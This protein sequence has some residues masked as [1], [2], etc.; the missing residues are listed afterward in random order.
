MNIR[1]TM[2]NAV[3]AGLTTVLAWNTAE[4]VT[5]TVT[6]PAQL[7]AAIREMG[8]RGGTIELAGEDWR[9]GA[10]DRDVRAFYISNH[11]Q[12]PDHPVNL[13]FVGC[14]NLVVRGRGQTLRFA[15]ATIGVLIQDSVGVRLENVKLDWTRPFLS[16]MT[17]LGYRDGKTLARIDA[18]RFPYRLEDGK[19]VH[20]GDGWTSPV[21]AAFAFRGDTHEVVERSCD[22]AYRGAMT[23][24]ADG[25]VT[26]AFDFSKVGM[27]LK[28]GDVV[29]LRPA[30]RP[31]PACVV[32]RAV[33]TALE[34]V[35]IH[36]AWGMG[37]ICQMSDGF[38]WRGTR[39]AEARTSGVFPPPDSGR[40]ATLHA[41]ASHFS[42]VKGLV[43]VEN[44]LFETMMD[45]AINVHSTCLA[46]IG[47]PA[48]NRIRCRYMHPQA[49]GFGVFNPGDTLRFIRGKTLENGSETRVTAVETH[50][51]REV[52]LT[53]AAPVPAGY[54]T[55]DAVENAT[56][57]CAV[58]FRG[59]VVRNNRARGALFTTPHPV[60]V[61]NN[62]F[63][64]VSG[65][66]ILFA[67]DAQGWYE[68]G[69]C[70]D[71]LVRGNVFRDCLTSVFQFCN[72]VIS[73]YPMIRE[74][75]NQKRH[76]HRNFRIEGNLFETFD[77][78]LLYALSTD[79]ITW[80]NNTVNRH[81][82]YR[83]WDKPAFIRE[84]CTGWHTGIRYDRWWNTY[85]DAYVTK[86]FMKAQRKA[87]VTNLDQVLDI[88]RRTHELTGG[89]RQIIY[90][91]GWQYDGHDSKW[92]CW[93]KVGDQCKSRLSEDPLQSLRAAMCLCR[94]KYNCDL[95]LHLNMNDAWPDSPAWKLYNDEKLLCLDKNGKPR[96][97]GQWFRIS[98]VKEWRSGYAKK[99]ID[100]LL[101]MLPELKDAKTVHID[102]FFAQDSEFDG[103][104]IEDDKKAIQTITDYWHS[105]GIDV[106][107]E[108]ITS[109]DMIGYFP[110]VY[111]FNFDERQ[112]LLYTADVICPGST[113]WNGRLF[114]DYFHPYK[115][116]LG[117]LTHSPSAGAIYSEAWGVG[118]TCDMTSGILRGNDLVDRLFR[119]AVLL[120]WYNRFP[121]A[122]HRMTSTDYTVTRVGDVTAN[123]RM[124]DRRLT[125][126]EKGRTV[127]DGA[128]YFLDFPW[129]GGTILA[130]SRQGCDRVFTV[131]ASFAGAAALT[132]TRYPQGDSVTLPVSAGRVSVKLARGESLVLRAR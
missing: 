76:Y 96:A 32:Y 64:N 112:R 77:V 92:P 72:G 1:N 79:D 7:R 101:A 59:N 123:V 8:P 4:A 22:I 126:T 102:A 119:S 106:T 128:D 46:V 49:I 89:M 118:N 85:T 52:T 63:L 3:V 15:G 23:A 17:V 11:D 108:F 14:T 10:E 35:V 33:D 21:S 58:D 60:R 99:R 28:P 50:D 87:P 107:N 115:N 132:G 110:M 5:K 34:D 82:R 69:A 65:S 122:D 25:T 61:E 62:K 117:P 9:F 75:A 66:A 81:A 80:R 88:V 18:Q 44:C 48:A 41:D 26:C 94:E 53:L 84:Q 104:T 100:A 129:G 6:S 42:N 36:T 125:V 24:N 124:K 103:I 93:D 47:T 45:D 97:L 16:E 19:F 86:I 31:Y 74:R 40:V 37:V 56:Y 43:T 29:T 83:G 111:H 113:V 78:P 70:E 13:P 114:V 68:S 38:T 51:E 30:R 57:Q 20:V 116:G 55:G 131:P 130:Y 12:S 2:V 73:S 67:G 90:L 91:V 127:V 54:G 27:G 98:H 120:A 109:D 95:S 121:L 39:T 71:V 105:R